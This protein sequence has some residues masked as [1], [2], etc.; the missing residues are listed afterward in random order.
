MTNKCV[1][2]PVILN[3]YMQK[4]P[5]DVCKV[6]DKNSCQ[7]LLWSLYSYSSLYFFYVCDSRLNEIGVNI[8][9]FFFIQVFFKAVFNCQDERLNYFNIYS[10]KLHFIYSLPL[11]Y[12]PSFR[13]KDGNDIL[14]C[15]TWH[16]RPQSTSSLLFT[17]L[18]IN[19]KGTLLLFWSLRHAF[20]VVFSLLETQAL[21]FQ[22]VRETW[23]VFWDWLLLSWFL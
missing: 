21:Y 9:V 22:I 14:N 10:R 23:Y 3:S 15:N 17:V 18:S 19:F 2:S 4:N 13:E 7:F 5:L 11:S 6:F 1:T 16:L 8:I 12:L 20:C